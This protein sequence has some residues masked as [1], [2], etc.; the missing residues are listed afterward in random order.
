MLAATY[1]KSRGVTVSTIAV[2]DAFGR[3]GSERMWRIAKEGGGTYNCLMKMEEGGYLATDADLFLDQ[4]QEALIVVDRS[5]SMQLHED[6]LDVALAVVVSSL[7]AENIRALGW[8][9]F[10]SSTTRYPTLN[11]LR[12]RSR[13]QGMGFMGQ[14]LLQTTQWLF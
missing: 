4:T 7:L 3:Q 10:S 13:C 14:A 9:A 6:T 8:V 2:V 5:A 11:T 12:K 1:L